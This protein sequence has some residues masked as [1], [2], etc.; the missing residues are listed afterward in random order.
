MRHMPLVLDG[1]TKTYKTTAAKTFAVD[2]KNYIEL[3]CC[4][5]DHEPNLR[6]VKPWTEVINFDELKA[7]TFVKNKKVFQGPI[8]ACA[9]GE[10]TAG[11]SQA[12]TRRLNGM[13]MIICSNHFAEDIDDLSPADQKY[14][15]ENIYDLKLKPGENMFMKAA[16]STKAS[17]SGCAHHGDGV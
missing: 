2:P 13:K 6:S 17:S 16:P 7:S 5:L 9:M 3:N 1:E 12:Y 4:N 10:N 8:G 11:G 14:I 15:W